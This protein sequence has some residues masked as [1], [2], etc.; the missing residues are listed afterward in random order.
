[1]RRFAGLA[2][3]AAL[4]YSL[5][6]CAAVRTADG[7]E[8]G[9][10]PLFN[11]VDLDGWTG[12]TRGYSVSEGVLVAD[13]EGNLYTRDQYDDFVLRFEFKLTPGANNGIGVRVP[14]YGRAS[15]DGLEIQIL[16]DTSEKFAGAA[17]HQRHGSVYGI[18]PAKT[19]HLRPVGEW[20]EEE[21]RVEGTRVTVVLN[22][23]TI[24]DA[25]LA[26][27]RDGLPAP[28]GKEHPGLSQTRGHLSLAGHKTKLYF[29]NLRIK[30]L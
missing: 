18:V 16:D 25:D 2:V 27:Y 6:G 29:R 19:G 12:D 14:L 1:M 10:V 8:R 11:G 7:P 5:A 22:G 3:A 30:P 28:D 13:P 15:R 23:A 17:P 26:P 9:F 21:I 20:N 24:V 4:V